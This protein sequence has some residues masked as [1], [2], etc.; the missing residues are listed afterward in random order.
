MR[1]MFNA[2]K[3]IKTLI[4]VRVMEGREDMIINTIMHIQ[5]II[6]SIYNIPMELK[7]IRKEIMLKKSDIS[8]K[9]LW[10]IEKVKRLALKR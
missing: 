9:S 8:R 4:L 5:I 7:L 3:T 2:F 6:K 1:I 10:M